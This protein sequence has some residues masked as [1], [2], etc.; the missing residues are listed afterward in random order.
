MNHATQFTNICTHKI[1]V[2][3]ALIN[4]QKKHVLKQAVMTN[5]SPAEFSPPIG[6]F[7]CNFYCALMLICPI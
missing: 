5:K 2:F 4:A 3:V 6:A 1:L 7:I